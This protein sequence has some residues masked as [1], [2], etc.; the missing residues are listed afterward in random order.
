MRRI[1]LRGAGIG[2]AARGAVSRARLLFA[3]KTALAVGIA[4]AI[5]PYMPGSADEYPYY[6]PFGALISMYPTL[7][8][9][10]KTG[11]QT[12]LGL[13]AGIGL[14]TLVLMTVGPSLWSIATVVGVGVIVSGTGWFGAGREYIPMA[15]LFVLIIG[16]ADAED[17]SFGYVTQTAVGVIIGLVVNMIIP[18]AP[19]LADAAVRIDAF[20]QRLAAHLDD[21]AAA[22]TETWPPERSDWMEDAGAIAETSRSLRDALTEADESRRG[23]PRAWRGRGDT[24]DEHARLEVLVEVSHQ[25]RDVSGCL[26][27]TIN[28]RPS[29]FPLDPALVDPLAAAC[30]AVADLLGG[31]DEDPARLHDR[32]SEAVDSL[33]RTVH[34]RSVEMDAVAGPGVLSAMH[35]QR[36][37]SMLEPPPEADGESDGPGAQRRR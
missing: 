33:L 10:A 18:P 13:G 34:S 5:A 12:L 2:S 22:L 36:I 37:I 19:L 31:A 30:Q 27:D 4:W 29:A 3:A 35:L 1:R 25:I 7:M 14:A 6:A 26:S 20:Q 21:I 24:S 28:D 16:G 9:S 15:A 32:A 17:Y 11:L 8:S 23:N